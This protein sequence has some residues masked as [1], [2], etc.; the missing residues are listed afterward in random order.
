MIKCAFGTGCLAMPRAFH[1]TGWLTGLVSTFLVSFLVVYAMNVLVK[2][3][4]SK[5]LFRLIF[6]SSSFSIFIIWVQSMETPI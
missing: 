4:V 5:P 2:N 6:Y 1:N 3:E